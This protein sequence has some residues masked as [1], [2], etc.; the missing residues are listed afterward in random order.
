MFSAAAFL[1]N[2]KR[3]I[4]LPSWRVVGVGLPLVHFLGKAHAGGGGVP[5]QDSIR[6]YFSVRVGLIHQVAIIRSL[7]MVWL[8]A[9]L[10]MHGTVDA[11]KGHLSPRLSHRLTDRFHHRQ[12]YHA[13]PAW[14]KKD[15]NAALI[16]VALMFS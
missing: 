8:S 15:A 10:Y 9:C 4:E 13:H 2:C 7:S 5:L 16:S 14:S 3:L 12:L 6:T 1:G 11:P